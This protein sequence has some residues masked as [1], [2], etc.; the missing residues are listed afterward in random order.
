MKTG[1]VYFVVNLRLLFGEELKEA[2]REEEM[3]TIVMK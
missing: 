3:E 2:L 1:D